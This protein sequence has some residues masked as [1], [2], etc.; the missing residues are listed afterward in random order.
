MSNT[1]VIRHFRIYA[2]YNKKRKIA[3]LGKSYAKDLASIYS[4]HICGKNPYTNE[5]FGKI[6][7]LVFPHLCILESVTG[8][9]REAYRRLICW[10]RFFIDSGY[11]M[12]MQSSTINYATS[13]HPKS[14]VIYD[15]IS[16]E[17]LEDIINREHIMR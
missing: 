16:T 1:S 5:H 11:T 14:K 4:K 17:P 2:L 12:L 9:Y 3:F 15:A 7:P 10:T 6:P 8:T 13:L